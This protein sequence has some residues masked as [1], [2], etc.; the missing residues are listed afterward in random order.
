MARITSV[1]GRYANALVVL[2][3]SLIILFFLLN[4][5]HNTFGG[6]IVGQAAGTVGARASGQSYTFQ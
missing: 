2:S 3:I 4:W 1:A 6:N 5:L